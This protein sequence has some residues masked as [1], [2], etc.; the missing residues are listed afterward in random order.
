MSQHPLLAPGARGLRDDHVQS[1]FSEDNEGLCYLLFILVR[2]GSLTEQVCPKCGLIESHTPRRAYK[3][4][5]CKAGVCRHDFSAKSGSLF[6][7]TKL[8]YW[9]ML[10]AMY[11]W[12]DP[13]KGISAVLLARKINVT[14]ESAYL[15]LRKFRYA[16]LERSLHFVFRGEVEMDALWVF[17][18]QR[19]INCRIPSVVKE[20]NKRHR[21]K[22][23]V[24]AMA[25]NPGLTREEA[26]RLAAA[27]IK[28]DQKT[29]WQNPN[30]RPFLAIVE[31]SPAGGMSRGVG[32]LLDTESFAHI[33]PLARRFV[34]RGASVFTDA[35]S[36]YSGLAAAYKLEQINHDEYYS[37]GPGLNTNA[38]E[39]SF[40]RFRR[41]ERGTYHRMS[42]GTANG[43][44]AENLWREEH[45][46]T[47]PG[48]RLFGFMC[49]V[50][51][52]EV[53]VELKKYGTS[54]KLREHVPRKITHMPIVLP[55]VD[56]LDRLCGLGLLPDFLTD[57]AAAA[58]DQLRQVECEPVATLVRELDT[59]R[60]LVRQLRSDKQE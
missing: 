60:L 26:R 15:L 50:I 28:L 9:K 10:K 53:C 48:K 44:M 51:R 23:A 20:V 8:P 33:E 41:M 2:W 36:A 22:Y 40:A 43:Y 58:R 24:Q 3:Q 4:W 56:A 38:V 57:R 27:Q 1:L 47:L 55:K 16:L 35:A 21:R 39:S 13:S 12:S 52:A 19:K 45:R 30:K 11:I 18:G 25:N 54:Q 59:L 42:P 32:F 7:G 6:D 37:R 34:D 46:H 49:C 31:R 29:H 5:R 14:Y 17:K